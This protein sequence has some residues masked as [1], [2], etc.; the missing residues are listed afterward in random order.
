MGD[1]VCLLSACLFLAYMAIGRRLRSWM[2]LFV[3]I[4]PV[5]LVRILTQRGSSMLGESE[6]KHKFL[7]PLHGLHRRRLQRREG[8]R[9]DYMSLPDS[10]VHGN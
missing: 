5:T 8:S 6:R 2:P 7:N 10:G 1:C 9:A 3:Y 4:F